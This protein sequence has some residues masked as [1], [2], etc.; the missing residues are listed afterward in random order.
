ML[1]EGMKN[2]PTICQWYVA[3]VLPQV[4]KQFPQAYCYHYMD[5]IL[6]AVPTVE[7]LDEVMPVM[8]EALTSYGLCVAP[9]KVQRQAPW[10]Y[11][12]MK[13]LDQTVEPQ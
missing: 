5:A 3:Q 1:P 2:S 8:Q 10:K 9:E 12:E 11:L 6:V 7:Q 13:I 4:R